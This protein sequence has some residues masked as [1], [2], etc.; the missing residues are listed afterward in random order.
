MVQDLCFHKPLEVLMISKYL[1]MNT[2]KVMSPVFQTL[3][4]REQ[5]LIMC[6]IVVLRCDKL[7]RV[8]VNRPLLEPTGLI[9]H[10]LTQ[11]A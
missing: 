5:L 1:K 6:V 7:A 8:E 11:N 3:N 9:W 4:Y 2:L 10:H